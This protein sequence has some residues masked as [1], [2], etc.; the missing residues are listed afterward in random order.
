MLLACRQRK[1][2]S[3]EQRELV[4][5]GAGPGGYVAALKAAQLGISCT[6]VERAEVG[7]TCLNRGCVPT[8]SVLRSAEIFAQA[9]EA[10]LFGVRIPEASVDFSAVRDRAQE[11]VGRIR[12]GVESLLAAN[13]IE[14]VRGE[15]RIAPGP[16]VKVTC[17]DGDERVF[18]AHDV[19]IATGS[20]PALPPIQG[21]DGPR[22]MTSDGMLSDVPC[23]GS[24]VVI[25]GGV[26]GVE[27][28]SA[29]ADFGAA[30]TVLEALPRLLPTLDREL[31]QSLALALKKRGCTV[32]TNALVREVRNET[33]GAVVVY[34]S[35]GEVR[36]VR[37]DA[38]LVA[39]GRRCDV[40]SLCAD[41]LE[42]AC[43]QG[44]IVVDGQLRT[45][46]PHVYA[47]GD[48]AAGGLQLAHVASAQGIA[49][50]SAI[51]NVPCEIDLA[52]VPSCVY[53][54][55]EISSVGMS[56][57]EA[58]ESGI[59]VQVG[60]Y[61]MTGNGKTVIAGM[62]RGF[63]KVVARADDGVVVGAQLLCGRATDLVG[64]LALAIA[65]GMTADE[66]ASVIRA[67]PTFEEGVGEALEAVFGCA[68]HSLPKARKA[69]SR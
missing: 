23:V 21:L 68:V 4:V 69:V 13:G 62:D 15:A 25:G 64:E 27:F 50:V 1:D 52:C 42:L 39:T 49:A 61:L 43:E 44:R 33:D 53:S 3:M 65:R 8:K 19:V 36:E 56:E 41:G 54:N 14:L 58:K 29:Y 35:K 5:V 45:S 9:K 40:A 24:L 51:A 55:P 67:H 20:E 60:K 17:Q 48:I 6:L 18:S 59:E 2:E 30:V 28:A 10:A 47:I 63:I 46:V 11:V 32:C 34:E 66:T 37:A 26:I 57:A 16:L 22:V 7:G 31:G 38:I 12:D